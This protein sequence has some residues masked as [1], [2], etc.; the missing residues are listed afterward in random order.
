MD[1]VWVFNGNGNAFPS[2]V[3]T[4]RERA[5]AWIAANGLGGMLTKYPLD[6]SVYEFAIENGWFTPSRDDHRSPAF[7][8]RFTS[9]SQE[10]YH[11]DASLAEPNAE[12]AT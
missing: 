10:H 4:T 2:G 3:F 5:E 11:Y 6:L 12:D 8:Q 9:A 1:H 7:I